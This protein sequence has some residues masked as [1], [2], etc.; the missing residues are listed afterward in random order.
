MGL[1]GTAMDLGRSAMTGLEDP[2]GRHRF[3][4]LE[5]PNVPMAGSFQI[6][7][8]SLYLYQELWH[9]DAYGIDHV[10]NI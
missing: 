4:A 9:M 6:F 7:P 5:A 1:G 8:R 3:T 10:L 2:R